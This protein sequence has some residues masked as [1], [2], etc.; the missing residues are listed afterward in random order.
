MAT[1]ITEECINCAACEPECPNTAIYQGGIEYDWQDGKHEA[2]SADLFYIVPEKCTECVGFFDQ[3]ACAAVCPVDCCIPDPE[4]PEEEGA[5]LER[6]KQLHPEEEFG[7]GFPSRFKAGPAVPAEPELA[8]APVSS[9]AP[10]EGGGEETGAFASSDSTGT[11]LDEVEVPINCRY[12]CGRYEVAFRFLRPGTV[13]RCP[14]CQ[15]GFSPT[16]RLYLAISERLDRW[17]DD[18]NDAADRVERIIET[19]QRQ[20]RYLSGQLGDRLSSDLRLIVDGLTEE[21]K[22]SIFG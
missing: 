15:A 1:V 8:K 3:E 14:H 22:R 18:T 16:Q 10:G 11:S 12:C 7:E 21:P 5:L 17:A 2:I 13:L 20:F 9:P 6:A 4:R 19:E